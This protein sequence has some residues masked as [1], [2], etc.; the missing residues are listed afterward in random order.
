MDHQPI[1]QSSQLRVRLR[2]DCQVERGMDVMKTKLT[3]VQRHVTKLGLCFLPWVIASGC[4][5]SASGGATTGPATPIL[6]T[7][8]AGNPV[9]VGSAGVSAGNFSTGVAGL[10]SP[11]LNTA[12]AG[13]G[14]LPVQSGTGN[15]GTLGSAAVGG[16][17][18]AV[19]GNGSAGMT[20]AA[21]GAG[22]AIVPVTY[23]MLDASKI[24][25]ASQVAM[26]FTLAE[27]PEW[28]HCG[29]QLLFVD[30][31][32]SVIHQLGADG[33]VGVFAMNTNYT[34]GISFDIDGSLIMAQMGGANGHGLLARR[35]ASGAVS[36]LVDKDLQ[37]GPF[38]T[39]DDVAVGSDG[40]IY[41][42][43]GDF[44]HG[45]TYTNVLG[46]TSQLPVYALKPGTGMRTLLKG[47]S[48]SGPNGIELS[49]DEKTLYVDGY[50]EGTVWKF[51]I[52]ADGTPQK[53]A[54]LVRGLTNPDSL[55][56]DAAGNLYVGVMAGL[57]VL[58]PDGSKVSLIP[59]ASAK[60]VTN[61]TFGGDDGKTLYIT[62]WAGLWKVDA[63]PIPG[64]DWTVNQTRVQ[65]K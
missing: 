23:P 17:I 51:A 22:G 35:D 26:G 21:A 45:T 4:G 40:T 18:A 1:E 61:C 30:V 42:S 5:S 57:Q 64:L 8:V 3:V 31:E 63:M 25:M 41:F 34:N 54:A 24:G 48:V 56:L 55:C 49:P 15:A 2:S 20:L 6:S 53:G 43:D 29:H 32:A 11:P 65:C 36:V 37:G 46:Y 28:D 12:G 58:R 60:G 14:T 13:I 59:I 44:A 52:G 10:M 7:G 27:G 47:D 39:V 19:G 16:S 50:G 9:A 38:H 33:K 62:A